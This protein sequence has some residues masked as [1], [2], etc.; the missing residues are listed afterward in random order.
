M[1]EPRQGVAVSYMRGSAAGDDRCLPLSSQK[2]Q[3]LVPT[4]ADDEAESLLRKSPAFKARGE[5]VGRDENWRCDRSWG[6]SAP[7]GVG[8]FHPEACGLP[9]AEAWVASDT[10]AIN[11]ALLIMFIRFMDLYEHVEELEEKSQEEKSQFL[12][13]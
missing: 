13:K 1:A 8:G 12:T 2:P 10:R 3:V 9:P 7:V 5:S 11:I 6:S 4:R